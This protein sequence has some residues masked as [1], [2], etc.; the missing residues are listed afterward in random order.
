[1]LREGKRDWYVWHMVIKGLRC[2]HFSFVT[3]GLRLRGNWY[4]QVSSVSL[5]MVL[6]GMVLGSLHSRCL[7]LLLLTSV[8][9]GLRSLSAPRTW[10]SVVDV[11]QVCCLVGGGIRFADH[12]VPTITVD[13][14]VPVRPVFMSSMRII[15]KT[16]NLF[17]VSMFS[18]DTIIIVSAVTLRNTVNKV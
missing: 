1:M 8:Y 4:K 2:A 18:R 13:I 7:L 16:S 14:T 11:L 15:W 10:V 3:A 17:F 6:I 5:K 12:G 9:W